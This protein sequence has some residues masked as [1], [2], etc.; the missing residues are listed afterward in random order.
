MSKIAINTSQNVN[1]NFN[2][3]SIGDRVMAFMLD[4]LIKSAYLVCL[5]VLVIYLLVNGPLGRISSKWDSWDVVAIIGI[6]TLPVHTYTLVCESLMEGQT[7]GKKIMKI[8]V[9]KIDGYQ[10]SFGDYLIR[11]LF[12]IVDVFTNSGIVGVLT[13]IYSKNNQRLGDMAE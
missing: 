13:I 9:V 4:M 8:K 7:F 11:W 10:A 2:L 12:R 6:I 3:A 1:I 5:Y